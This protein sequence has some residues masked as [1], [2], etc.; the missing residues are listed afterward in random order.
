MN[1]DLHRLLARQLR[2]LGLDA[3]RPPAAATWPD[4]LSSIDQTYR[5]ADLDRY[6]LERS[7]AISS[8]EMRTLYQ[9]QM[10]SY[11]ARLHALFETIQD[12]IW[13][14]NPQGAYLACNPMAERFFGKKEAE[15]VGKTDYDLMDKELADLFREGDRIAMAKGGPSVNERWVTFAD[16]GRRAAMEVVKTPMIDASGQLIGVLGIARDI[17]E[18]KQIEERLRSS[19]ALLRQTQS[20]AK[21]GSWRLNV[22]SN[23]LEWSDETYRMFGIPAG[24][25]MDYGRF[26]DLVHPD[27]RPLVDSAWHAALKG[28]PYHI[29]HR[30]VVDGEIRWVEERAQSGFNAQSDLRSCTGSVQDITERKLLENELHLS[31]EKFLRVFQDS[32]DPI[33]IS[34]INTGVVHEINESFSIVF[35]YSSEEVIGHTTTEFGLWLDEASRNAAISTIK[36]HGFLRNHEV[37]QRAKDGRVLTFLA[38]TTPLDY[39][40]TTFLVVHLRD[41]TE[42]KKA[43]E[44]LRIA[45]ATFETHDAI[46]ITD[47]YSNIVRVNRA[48]SDITGYSE[49]EVL[50]KNP[51]IMSSGRHDRSF[52]IEM[53]QDLLHAG[54]WAGEIWDKRKNGEIYP[55]WMT[56]TAVRNEQQE[57]THYVAI[58]SD[59][60]AR[61]LA[62]EEI[63]RLAFYDAL[64]KLPNRRLLLDRLSVALAASARH[65]DYGAV[66]F[67]D[68]DHFKSL[69]D[70]LGHDYGDLLL[71]EVGARIKSCVRE[72]DTVA[73]FGGDEFVVLIEAIGNDREDAT[74]K[75]ALVAEKIREALSMPHKLKRHEHHCSTSIGISL[76]HGNDQSMDI[77]IEHADMA[78]YQ[79]KGI[80]R[81]AV[82]FFDPVMQQNVAIHDAFI[83]DL[84]HA[85][86]LQQLHLHYQIQVDNDNRPLGAEAFLRWAHPTRG[87][88]LPGQFIRIAEEGTL[89]IDI[90]RWVLQTVCK[91]LALWGGNDKTR[92]LTLTVNI[93]DKYFAQPDFVSYVIGIL[94]E[95]RADP[96]C[97]KLELPERLVMTDINS[98]VQKIQS[99]KNIGVRLSMDNFSTVYA[100]LSSLKQLSSDQ[101][102]IHQEFVQAMTSEG[103]DNQLVK[104]LIELA[105]SLG[106]G[107]FAAEV[108]HEGQRA[109]LKNHDCNAYQGYLFGKPLPIEQFEALLRKR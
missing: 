5:D 50:G 55:K 4:L 18:R 56:V 93:S 62:E 24:T 30:I 57:T 77:L 20:V 72:I 73:R 37:Q 35:G 48:F 11:E 75:I 15:I 90:D 51:R 64:T 83:N 9:S 12:L 80:G 91:Q 109:F 43:E 66:L 84:H 52:Y 102:K 97:L 107:I 88:L 76:Y 31:E 63:R 2:K 22:Q 86:A 89:I 78:M 14:K 47:K 81:N 41:I 25:P 7:L 99:L 45:A 34:E 106:L 60:T 6:T 95:H 3:Q 101:L 94:N 58:F 28:T 49:D 32:P 87:M 10:S 21:I 40:G 39:K 68:L 19:E 13:L 27:D 98:T 17:T 44:A 36:S 16:D 96:A 104:T 54:Y 103:S 65:D 23:E 53:W 69:N 85:I 67:I 92:G 108:E 29:Q 8:E 105:K 100:S 26:L 74:R 33:L 1:A 59:I 70:M 46:L 71:I 42:R 82:H 79:A 38:S 61:K